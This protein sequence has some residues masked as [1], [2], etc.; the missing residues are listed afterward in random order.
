MKNATLLL[1][2][3]A[4]AS[5]TSCAGVSPTQI[6]GD[7]VGAAGGALI[8]NQL[9]HGNPLI[10]AAAAGGGALLSESLQAGRKA[11]ANKAYDAGYEK[12]RRDVAK[13]QFQTLI[14]RQRP[15]RS[16]DSGR[17]TRARGFRS[18]ANE[19]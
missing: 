6:I 17:F 8:G 12:A 1:S 11:S 14:D 13:Q 10:T 2:V 16:R 4:S 19:G 3:L 18:R 15:A 7:T 9:S 5:L